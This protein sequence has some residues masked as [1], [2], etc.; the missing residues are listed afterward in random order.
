MQ[1]FDVVVV[2]SGATGAIGAKTLAEKGKNVTV[3]DGGQTDEKYNSI[4]PT[5]DW[6]TLRKSDE[7]QHRY[8][9]GDH[10]EGIAW[11]EAKVGSQLTPAR[12]YL[13]A[14]V[15]EYLPFQSSSLFP[16]ESLA[17][18]G[19]GGGWGLGCF[20]FSEAELSKCGL[21]YAEMLQS[22][23]TV[24]DWIGISGL[25]DDA[26]VYSVGKLNRL[27]PPPSLE[28]AM[29][30]IFK[31]YALKKR[32]LQ[33]KGFYLGRSGIALLTEE[34]KDRNSVRNTDMEYWNDHDRSSYRSWMTLEELNTSGKISHIKGC[35]VLSFEENDGKVFINALDISTNQKVVFKCNKLILCAGVLSTAR[36]VLRSF[37]SYN[38]KIPFLCNPYSYMPTLQWN[39]F[40]KTHEDRKSGIGQAILFHDADG[41]QSDVAQAALFS[42]RQLLLFKLVKESP[43]GFASGRKIMQ[44]LYPAFV[45]AGIHHTE[46]RGKEKY[47]ELLQDPNQR[48]GDVLAG[49]YKLSSDEEVKIARREA[50]YKKALIQLG[51]LPLRSI[52]TPHGGSI[53]YA[54]TLPYSSKG[55]L[56]TLKPN[57]KMN[58]TD[59][60]WIADGSGFNYLPA[61][62]LTFTLMANAHRVC[63][64][65][66][67]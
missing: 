2:G 16:F 39:M 44:L 29:Q 42:Y 5:T 24:S 21:P 60:V 34:R 46:E 6:L 53:H 23:Q 9:L 66:N 28:K 33:N 52:R 14:R 15:E 27:L 58:G 22:Y 7:N 18:G 37:H 57:G 61:K 36:I 1:E 31:K 55:E 59:N 54:G 26:G 12:N 64:Q 41:S 65:I 3:I 13:R 19:L 32:Q 56:L 8:F 20:M 40:G 62:G 38:Q 47:V 67:S 25:N 11:K 4:T 43:L 51:C 30:P 35:L 49:L 17:V 48:T 63:S 10:F 50:L 45:V